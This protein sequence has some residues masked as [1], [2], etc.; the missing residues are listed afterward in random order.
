M[1]CKRASHFESEEKPT[2][3]DTKTLSA[4]PSRGKATAK[5]TVESED[6]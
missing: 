2:E 6:M 3:T 5:Q 1:G 4:F